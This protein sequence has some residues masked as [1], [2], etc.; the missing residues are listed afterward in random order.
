MLKPGDI[1]LE[2]SGKAGRVCMF[3]EKSGEYLFGN[4][5]QRFRTDGDLCDQSFLFWYLHLLYLGGGAAEYQRGSTIQNL[6]YK[7]YITQHIPLPPI[8]EQR[9]IV[10]DLEARMAD[11]ERARRAAEAQLA[12]AEALP[13][14]IL[15]G[16]F[17]GEAA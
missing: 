12:A 7:R 15:R 5:C 4:F 10:A 14:A 11:A 8:D 6:Q 17:A 3:R 1:L 9:R 16:A 2:R 13:S